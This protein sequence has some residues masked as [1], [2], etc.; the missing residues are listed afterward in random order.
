MLERNIFYA[1]ANITSATSSVKGLAPVFEYISDLKSLVCPSRVAITSTRF[2]EAAATAIA[3]SP[4]KLDRE[5][6]RLRETAFRGQIV[7]WTKVGSS[8]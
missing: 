6:A 3:L 7:N 8:F 1:R 4:G 5:T 2:E